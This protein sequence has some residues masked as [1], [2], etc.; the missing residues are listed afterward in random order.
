MPKWNTAVVADQKHRD[1]KDFFESGS[2]PWEDR[3]IQK[4][5]VG[6]LYEDRQKTVVSMARDHLQQGAAVL[7]AGCGP[8]YISKGL[9]ANGFNVVGCDLALRMALVARSQNNGAGSSR[10]KLSAVG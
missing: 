2:D 3:Y 6:T 8:G 7:D 1:V 9:A 10:F 5:M 4:G